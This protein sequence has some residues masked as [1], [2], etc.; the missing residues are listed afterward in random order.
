MK[1]IDL[2]RIIQDL[3]DD[4]EIVTIDHLGNEDE[5]FFIHTQDKAVII[6]A[7]KVAEMYLRENPQDLVR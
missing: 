5:P 2:K 6:V 3:P 7:K 4:T 1:L